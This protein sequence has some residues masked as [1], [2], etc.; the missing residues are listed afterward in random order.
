MR[1][2]SAF[3]KATQLRP[4]D[5]EAQLSAAKALLTLLRYAEA[6]PY[7]EAV[8]P[9]KPD[10]AEIHALR[11]LIYAHTA[12]DPQ[13]ILELQ[14]AVQLDPADADSQ[15][16][17]GEVLRQV[18][19]L[20]EAADYL[21]A[22]A[23]L[24]RTAS[25]FFQL[26][27]TYRALSKAVEQRRAN[28]ALEALEEER[29]QNTTIDVLKSEAERNSAGKLY[30]KAAE[31]YQVALKLRPADADLLFRLALVRGEMHQPE[32]ERQLLLEALSKLP[33][34][35][36]ALT[37]LGRLEAAAGDMASARTHFERPFAS[38][39]KVR[40]RSATSPSSGLGM[41]I[42]SPQKSCSPMP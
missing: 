12:R 33:Q 40:T 21:Q 10:S 19:R 8:A 16:R 34:H 38:I 1:G 41:A 22:A 17:L 32:V 9:G 18:G 6:E 20:S 7:L 4:S 24:K 30:P 15:L 37:A 23:A 25:A 2:L 14:E 26:S 39:R 35:V 5:A 31:L 13:A 29:A 27:R 3:A 42:W 36:G 28:D 11:G